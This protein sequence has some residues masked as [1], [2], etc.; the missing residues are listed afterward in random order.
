M[1][2][3]FGYTPFLFREATMRYILKRIIWFIMD[4]PM[5]LTY[6]F[7]SEIIPPIPYHQE[8]WLIQKLNPVI[9][10]KIFLIRKNFLL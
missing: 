3:S 2:Y 8:N 1:V 9:Y 5:H 4:I 7:R 6:R 10:N